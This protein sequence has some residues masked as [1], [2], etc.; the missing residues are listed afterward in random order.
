MGRTIFIV[1]GFVGLSLWLTG[2]AIFREFIVPNI[3]DVAA[4]LQES[5]ARPFDTFPAS[6]ATWSARESLKDTEIELIG[7]ATAH[8]GWRTFVG[9]AFW[10]PCC[11]DGGSG[12]ALALAPGEIVPLD[13]SNI[14]EQERPSC[15]RLARCGVHVR[16]KNI[17]H[18]KPVYARGIVRLPG[19]P[20]MPPYS[21]RRWYVV[22]IHDIGN[23]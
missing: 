18:H 16:C 14:P 9:C 15:D 21:D 23:L 3:S 20:P 10:D 13:L 8:L 6:Q 1:V 19:V 4:A 11:N 17:D 22:E 7:N 12:F 2:P 5:S